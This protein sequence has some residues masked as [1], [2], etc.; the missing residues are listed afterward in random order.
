LDDAIVQLTKG[1]GSQFDPRVVDKFV[2]LLKSGDV[3]LEAV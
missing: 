3:Q 1:S 2:M